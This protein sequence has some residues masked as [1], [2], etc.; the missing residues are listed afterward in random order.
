MMLGHLFVMLTCVQ[1][2][3]PCCSA[4]MS[5]SMD[6]RDVHTRA[7]TCWPLPGPCLHGSGGESL[8]LA[9]RLHCDHVSSLQGIG[10]SRAF[11]S[12]LW[13]IS[14]AHF[15]G[16]QNIST[17]CRTVCIPTIHRHP[18]HPNLIVSPGPSFTTHHCLSLLITA[19]LSPCMSI[20]KLD[21]SFT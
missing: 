12:Q 11:S 8:L 5:R 21:A 4:S 2:I 19:L 16:L 9:G 7:G 18:Y 14:L 15:P 1:H 20:T 13:I 17:S 3:G 6:L 10:W